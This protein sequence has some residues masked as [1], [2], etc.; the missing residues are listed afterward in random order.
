VAAFCLRALAVGD[1]AAAAAQPTSDT[2][3]TDTLR[4]LDHAIHRLG[5]PSSDYRTVLRDAV[6]SFPGKADDTPAADVRT[7]LARAPEPGSD[8][9]CSVDF[10]RA[11]ARQ[12]LLRLRDA[13]RHEYVAPLQPAVCYTFPYALELT[14]ARRTGWLDIYGYDFDRVAPEMVLVTRDGYRDVTAALVVRS[15]YHLAFKLG[16]DAAPWSSES[17]SLGL[18]WGHVIHHSIA[19]VQ[20]TSPL[21]SLRVERIPAGRTISYGVPW[22]PGATVWADATLDYSSN[23]LEATICVA[24]AFPAGDDTSFSGCMVDFLHTTD[25]GWE[26]EAVLGEL[27]SRATDARGT[28]TSEARNGRQGPVSQW[29]FRRPEPDGLERGDMS[30]T[31]RLREARLVAIETGECVSPLAYIEARRTAALESATRQA[32]DPQLLRIDRAVLELRPRFSLPTP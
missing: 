25:P 2:T 23:K 9:R 28:R 4:V 29:V 16:D 11:R 10:V 20:P 22:R 24:A 19:L 12:A 27:T 31:A 32:L 3:L 13:L 1:I 17:V 26:I 6:T 8:F 18:T 15:H 14:Q 7:F 30:V 21:C 5:D